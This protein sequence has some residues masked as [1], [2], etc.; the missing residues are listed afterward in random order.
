MAVLALFLFPTLTILMAQIIRSRRLQLRV[1]DMMSWCYASFLFVSL[2]IPVFY[3]LGQLSIR[4]AHDGLPMFSYTP[5]VPLALLTVSL[6]LGLWLGRPSHALEWVSRREAS[7]RCTIRRVLHAALR[8]VLH[9]IL[10]VLLLLTIAYLWGFPQFQNINLDELLFYLSM[11]LQGTVHSFA[12]GVKQFVL[13]PSVLCFLLL[14]LAVWLPVHRRKTRLL[15]SKR[16]GKTLM[17]LVPLRLPLI[18]LAFLLLS[19]GLILFICGDAYLDVSAF[20]SSRIQQSTLIRDEYA[21]PK[22][23]AITFPEGKKRNLISIYVESAETTSQDVANGGIFEVNHIP[24]MTKLAAENVSFSRSD[25]FQGASVPP[26]C[27]WTIAGLVAQTA[28]VPLK[29]YTYEGGTLG[30][31]NMSDEFQYFLPGATTLGD[32]LKDAGYRNV[33]MA[34]S[35]FVFG[36]RTLYYTQHGEYEIFDLLTAKAKGLIPPE[37]MVGWGF[38]D[39][40]LY[41]YARDMLTELSQQ[42]QPFHLAMLTVDTHAPFYECRLCPASIDDHCAKVLSCCSAQLNDF[43]EWCKAQPFYE[44]TTIVITGDHASIVGDFYDSVTGE[45]LDIHHGSTHRLVYNAFI[46]PAAEP[47]QEKNRLFTTLDFFPTTL[48]SLGVTIEGDRLGLGTNL[49][50]DQQTLSEKNGE[51]VLFEELDKKSTFYNIEL[52]YP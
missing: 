46:N 3:P 50:S 23:T 27:G 22:T 1:S 17:S 36:G 28:G 11:P 35:D 7:P 13:L 6:A 21:D 30:V 51:G 47:V 39:E 52:L 38:E 49:F 24:E 29:L 42:E 18:P 41:T 5:M 26:A 9:A 16:T 33:F 43:I 48:A 2:T 4:A 15:R 8:L 14:E 37:Y 20:I 31:D 25:R 32:I 12:Q 45:S 34:G 19:W 40:K 10:F 44:N